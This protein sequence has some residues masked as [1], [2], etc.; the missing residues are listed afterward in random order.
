MRG[1]ATGDET[2]SPHTA[3][4]A[5][6]PLTLMVREMVPRAGP[7]PPTPALVLR[8]IAAAGGQPWFP[9]R[10]ATETGTDRDSLDDPLN[11]LRLADLVRITTWERGVGQGYVL[12]PEGEQAVA[13]GVGIPGSASKPAEPVHSN[14]EPAV[15][16]KSDAGMTGFEKGEAAYL[17]LDPRPP[18]VTIVLV[19]ANVLWYF[20]GVV[21]AIRAGIPFAQF[22]TDGNNAILHR[23]G[24]LRGF[25]LVHDDWWRLLSACFVHADVW[26]VLM[27]LVGL[28]VIGPL[29]ELLWGRWRLVI[30][31]VFSG[32]AGS[33][34]AMAL[35][36]EVMVV[37]ASGAIWGV[38]TAAMAWFIMFRDRLKPDVAFVSLRRLGLAILLNA[39]ISFLPGISW[40]GHLGGAIAGFV[41]AGLLNAIRFSSAWRRVVALVLLLAIPVASVGGLVATMKWGDTW[42]EIR[43]REAAVESA[44]AIAAAARFVQPRRGSAAR[45][46]QPGERPPGGGSGRVA[47][48]AT[49]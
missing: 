15:A 22:L 38:M 27:N 19:I 7:S 11:Q 5:P 32:L 18:L 12:T 47:T 45:P 13:S 8:W 36:P 48:G 40:E 16:E 41:V 24:G 34:M 49:R 4:E 9:S 21:A 20:V 2:I 35:R 3:G 37:G 46:T 43:H 42:A 30:I 31:Y 26:H 10:H 44:R 17:G 14:S 28:A 6:L 25:D 23:T 1:M 29:T 33:C 39:G